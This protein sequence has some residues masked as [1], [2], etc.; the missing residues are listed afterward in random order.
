MVNSIS[1]SQSCEVKNFSGF[2][3]WKAISKSR[4]SLIQEFLTQWVIGVEKFWK[5]R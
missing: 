4:I 5:D 3:I 2:G 1:L